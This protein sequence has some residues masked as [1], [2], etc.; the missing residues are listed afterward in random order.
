MNDKVTLGY[1]NIKGL[2]HVPRLLLEY[3]GI[4]Y[5]DKLYTDGEEWAK[6]KQNLGFDFPNLP[7]IIDGDFKLTESTAI[8]KWIAQKAKNSSL[9]GKD[10]KDQLHVQMLLGVIGDIITPY[11]TIAFTPKE[12]FESVKAAEMAKVAPKFALLSKY[13]GKKDWFLGYITVADFQAAYVLDIFSKLDSKYLNEWKNLEE[14]QARLYNLEKIKSYI[15][16]DRYPKFYLPPQYA[17]WTG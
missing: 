9:L 13:L 14:L 1:W 8:W 5:T 10:D 11:F 3:T 12:A 16:S 7:Y 4:P 6:D 17:T 15:V 2:G